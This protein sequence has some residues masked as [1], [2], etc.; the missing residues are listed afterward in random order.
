MTNSFANPLKELQSLRNYAEITERLKN[1]ELPIELVGNVHAKENLTW[2]IHQIHLAASTDTPQSVLITGG[3][4]GDEPAGVEAALQFLERDN[5][6]LLKQFS[7][8]IIP[9]VNPYG[10]VH[11]TRET[12]NHIDINRSFETDNI[13]EVAILKKILGQTQFAF[14]IDFH[15]DYEATG[16]Y[17]YEGTRDEKHIGPQLAAAAKAIGPVDPEDTD[18]EAPNFVE[19]VY[20]V[21]TEWGTQGLAPY[22]LHFHS[23]HVIIS[24]TPTV[25]QLEQRAA[26][27][28]TILDTALDIIS[29]IK[30]N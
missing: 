13:A 10:Y 14:A 17:L 20:K 7:F 22:L 2:P 6:E 24:E 18:K 12:R 23:K 16:F 30:I 11:E 27:H 28:L 5:T 9:C 26:L 21:A 3:V 29:E 1:L 25:W 19:G 4:H 8:T 15:E